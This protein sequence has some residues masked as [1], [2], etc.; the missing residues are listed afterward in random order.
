MDA[1]LT[2]VRPDACRRLPKTMRL[3]MACLALAVVSFIIVFR[4][5]WFGCIV[6][7][8]SVRDVPGS[9]V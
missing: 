9:A 4:I 6:Y 5:L 8:G 7:A 2:A 3:V 1:S